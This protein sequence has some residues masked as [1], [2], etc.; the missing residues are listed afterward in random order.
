MLRD[1]IRVGNS[2]GRAGKKNF[3]RAFAKLVSI[4]R[5]TR[6]PGGRG[7]G[8]PPKLSMADP[9]QDNQMRLFARLS[10]LWARFTVQEIKASTSS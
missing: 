7:G 4:W 1:S 10:G 2:I 5:P 8:A 9:F 3:F 6:A